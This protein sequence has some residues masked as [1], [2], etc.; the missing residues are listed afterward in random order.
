MEKALHLSSFL[1]ECFCAVLGKRLL[2]A[3]L[4]QGRGWGCFCSSIPGPLSASRGFWGCRGGA[5]GGAASQP[6]HSSPGGSSC[7][8]PGDAP[9][10][11]SGPAW[12]AWVQWPQESWKLPCPM[13]NPFLM[14]TPRLVSFSR[15]NT[16]WYGSL[17]GQVGIA[18]M[19]PLYVTR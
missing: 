9:G 18:C 4:G 2:P 10:V 1:P 7:V 6:G 14:R 15:G 16:S 5:R 3:P 17:E 11:P 19:G 13:W 12:N 8:D